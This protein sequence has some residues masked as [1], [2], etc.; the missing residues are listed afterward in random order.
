MQKW[1]KILPSLKRAKRF[2]KKPFMV[3]KTGILS[4][5]DEI[6]Q[7]EDWG[8]RARKKLLF[9]I[10]IPKNTSWSPP[11]HCSRYVALWC[12]PRFL[13]EICGCIFLY[14][15]AI[16]THIQRSS[17]AECW[18]RKCVVASSS[19]IM[20]FKTFS[21]KTELCFSWYFKNLQLL[22]T[23]ENFLGSALANQIF[24]IYDSSWHNA[25]LRR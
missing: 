14:F 17:V 10:E 21:L 7:N 18:L 5:I 15:S 13:P 9:C 11:A 24:P 22:T 23:F 25:A 12:H 4:K 20:G 3:P 16:L 1:Q 19:P 8:C 2:G 6:W